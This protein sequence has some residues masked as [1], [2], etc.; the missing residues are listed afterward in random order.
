MG[1]VVCIMQINSHSTLAT[2]PPVFA[3]SNG[4]RRMD[5]SACFDAPP[6][7]AASKLTFFNGIL[8]H[9]IAYADAGFTR[10]T[11]EMADHTPL[12]SVLPDDQTFRRLM[13]LAGPEVG[14]ELLARLA[15]DLQAV[16]QGLAL[17]VAQTDWQAIRA[18]SHVL[19]AL[20]GAVGATPLQTLAED[21]NR[22]AHLH[23]TDALP[24]L[25][26]A[27]RPLLARL[28]RHVTGQQANLDE[29]R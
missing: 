13:Q 14:A 8:G 17:G 23:Q 12:K 21:F 3:R 2:W 11:T 7:A 15:E 24:G 28:I 18:H 25:L 6:S 10:Q 27:T 1:M 19:V 9:I 29:V 26:A 16:E 5:T 20:A 22:T 4:S